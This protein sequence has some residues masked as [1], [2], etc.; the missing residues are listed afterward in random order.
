M[1]VGDVITYT[2][3]NPSPVADGYYLDCDWER[4]T[5]VKEGKCPVCG[6]PGLIFKRR[7]LTK[8]LHSLRVVGISEPAPADRSI[9]IG[10]DDLESCERG[11]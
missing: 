10:W 6:R 3:E 8:I 11:K 4:W 1:K 9:G 5:S 7:G 2:K